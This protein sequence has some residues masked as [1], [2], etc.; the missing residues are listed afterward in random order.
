V[1]ACDGLKGCLEVGEGLDAVELAGFDERGDAAPCGSALV[2]LGEECVL[3]TDVAP[4]SR[5]RPF[6]IYAA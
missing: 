1:A 2:M 4:E 5:T 3:A 6:F